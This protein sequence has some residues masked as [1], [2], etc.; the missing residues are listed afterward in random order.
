MFYVFKSRNTSPKKTLAERLM[1]LPQIL[2]RHGISVAG[3][4]RVLDVTVWYS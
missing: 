4:H 1:D 3:M 2:S